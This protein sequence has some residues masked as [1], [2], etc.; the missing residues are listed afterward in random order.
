MEN[1]FH[2]QTFWEILMMIPIRTQLG[3]QRRM[4]S[5]ERK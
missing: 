3:N 2:W 4:N 1:S 5:E